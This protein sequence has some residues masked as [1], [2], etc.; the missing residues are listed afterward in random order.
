[1][2]S[3]KLYEV[4]G[5]IKDLDIPATT[6]TTSTTTTTTTAP[7]T[8]TTTS[9]TT[10]T[11]TLP[12]IYTIDW[13]WTDNNTVE[14]PPYGG[15]YM[16][17]NISGSNVVSI[18]DTSSTGTTVYSGSVTGS[19]GDAVTVIV[20]SYANNTYGTQTYLHVENPSG[21]VAYDNYDTQASPGSPSSESFVYA[22][23]GSGLITGSSNSY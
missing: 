18:A 12:P 1:M 9:T 15:G 5:S 2:V 8:T 23:S 10:T 3:G 17:I 7:T 22:I 11:T 19:L 21:S 16:T 4:Y 6:T 20:Y 14:T 13:Q